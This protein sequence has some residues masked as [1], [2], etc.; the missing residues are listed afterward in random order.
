[1]HLGRPLTNDGLDKDH[2]V[3]F[4]RHGWTIASD[5]VKP[6]KCLEYIHTINSI[7]DRLTHWSTSN[8]LQGINE[9]H[10][11]ETLFLDLFRHSGLLQSIRQLVGHDGSRVR[12]SIA[13]K[14]SPHPQRHDRNHSLRDP[15]TWEW[16]RD[17][18]PT[19]ILR[20]TADD[21]LLTSQVIVAATYYTDVSA[22]NG[23][24]ALLDGSHLSE[25]SYADLQDAFPC[26]EPEI[27]AGSVL[28]FTESLLHS[29]TPIV[30]A[31]TRFAVMTWMTAP[32]FG[33]A[34][35]KPHD[36]DRWKDREMRSLFRD[37]Y[38]G[39]NLPAD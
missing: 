22:G 18:Q 20:P 2:L 1:M 11:H 17:F 15:H 10:L 4:S 24:T 7:L 36:V 28:F 31:A 39:D 29:A 32:W 6:S 30:T 3:H 34:H 23:S 25:G 26:I 5:I 33:G 14:T 16:H 38:F 37:P 9:P 8:G 21:D 13:L 27:R 35:V 19:S 12:H